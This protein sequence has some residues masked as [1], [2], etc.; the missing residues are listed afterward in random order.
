MPELQE[1]Y[2]LENRKLLIQSCVE[3]ELNYAEISREV[4]CSLMTAWQ[5]VQSFFPEYITKRRVDKTTQQ[6]KLREEI[7]ICL[8]EKHMSISAIALELN[9][10]QPYVTQTV[11]NNFPEYSPAYKIEKKL[12][13]AKRL[14]AEGSDVFSIMK[15]LDL[16][17]SYLRFRFPIHRKLVYVEGICWPS[18]EM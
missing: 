16:S 7:K 11:Q 8:M 6:D 10:P 3:R 9:V 12:E 13:Q 14:Y 1:Q 5:Y 15:T 4:G 18:S 2:F 17:E